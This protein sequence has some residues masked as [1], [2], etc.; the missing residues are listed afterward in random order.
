MRF[1]V[2]LPVMSFD[3]TPV[4]LER[5]VAVALAAEEHG[6]DTV[7]VNDHL[8]YQRP[9]LDG[10][11]ALTAILASAPTVT[12]MTS[13]ALPVVRGPV[14]LAKSLAAI[15]LLS[16]GRLLAGLGPGSAAADYEAVGVPFDERWS[17]FDEAVQAVRALWTEGS[18]FAG[19]FYDTTGVMLSPGPAQRGGPPIYIGSWGSDGGLRRVARLADGWLASA[20]N[21]SPDDFAIARGRLGEVLAAEGR[22]ATTFPNTLATMWL[23]ITD[24]PVERQTVLDRLGA[25]LKRDPARLGPVLPIG[26]AAHCRRVVASYGEVGVDRILFWPLG[27]EV[28][29]L[30]RLADEVID[31]RARP[32]RVRDGDA[33][34]PDH[35]GTSADRVAPR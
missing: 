7:S 6:L 17:R 20:Y 12:L 28:R 16:G 32:S 8:V 35:R 30:A 22:D 29:Q 4:T 34:G 18:A 21:T 13:V 19:R 10:P 31:A 11:S 25:L 33:S 23:W 27:D 2:H 1:G 26:S 9:W 14:A 15:D 24:D 3:D 5:L